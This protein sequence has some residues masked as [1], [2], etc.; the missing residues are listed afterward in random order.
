MV[1]YIFIS[2]T[3]NNVIVKSA[4]VNGYYM[5]GIGATYDEAI[6]HLENQFIKAFPILKIIKKN[7]GTR[8]EVI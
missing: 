6:S 1:K 7:G 3:N 2:H 4:V 8:N 5:V